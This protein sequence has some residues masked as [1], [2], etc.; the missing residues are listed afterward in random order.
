MVECGLGRSERSKVR[1]RSP[2]LPAKS[3]SAIPSVDCALF[4]RHPL[5]STHCVQLATYYSLHATHLA[6]PHLELVLLARHP[7]PAAVSHPP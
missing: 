7:A 5:L 2:L 1:I 3:E 6:E 4:L